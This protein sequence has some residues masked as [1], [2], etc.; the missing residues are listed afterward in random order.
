[1]LRRK[2]RATAA[3]PKRK[4]RTGISFE[5]KALELVKA[6]GFEAQTTSRSADGGVDIIAES[7]KPFIS[8][9]YIIQC[10]DWKNPV[11]EPTLRDLLGAVQKNKAVKGILIS[12]SAFTRSA[13]DFAQGTPLEL[14]D[15]G[16]IEAL[17]EQAKP[18]GD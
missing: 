7:R 13:R 9:R 5:N 15:G 6:L 8:G 18:P 4:D 1:M 14:I 16:N 11:G 10:K 2:S 17:I 3:R 12:R